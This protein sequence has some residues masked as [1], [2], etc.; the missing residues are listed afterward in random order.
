MFPLY[1][2]LHV[3]HIIDSHA[4]INKLVYIRIKYK[5]ELCNLLPAF[6]THTHT[7]YSSAPAS[8]D[9]HQ[10]IDLNVLVHVACL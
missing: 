4:V 1:K 3:Q 9:R 8:V 5:Y 6:H 7:R 10:S 2:A